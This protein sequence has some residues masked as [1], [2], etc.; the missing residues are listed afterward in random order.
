MQRI[1]ICPTGPDMAA[2]FFFVGFFWHFVVG[3]LITTSSRESCSKESLCSSGSSPKSSPF[4]DPLGVVNPNN[5]VLSQDW[6]N[7]LPV[8]FFDIIQFIRG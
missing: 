4:K 6:L 7:V 3:G 2:G 8:S 1:E 5:L